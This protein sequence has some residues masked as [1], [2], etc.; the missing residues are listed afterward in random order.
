MSPERALQSPVFLFYLTLA[1]SLLIVAGIVF[2]ILRWGFRKNLSHALRAYGGWLLIVPVLLLAFFL[3]REA[4]ILLVILI[5]ALCFREFARAAGLHAEPF[6][7]GV[8][9]IGIAGLGLACLVYDPVSGTRGWYSLF[10]T[11]PVLIIAVI[12][13]IPIMQDR[14]EGQLQRLALA[15]FG[16]IY[17][18]WLLGHLAFL[19]NSEHAYS[20]L[21]YVVLAVELNDVAAYVCGKLIGRH[22]LRRNISPKKTWEGAVGALAFSLLLPW[23]M[24]FTLPDFTVLDCII[25]G[26]IVGIGGQLG[27][28]VI[29]VI[30]RDVG[31]KDMGATIPGHGGILDRIDSLIYVAPLWF[32]FIRFRDFLRL[33]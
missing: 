2:A 8:V 28:L 7:I 32:Y 17:F 14:V 21:G 19:A 26:L 24:R 6:M 30:K 20:Y 31:L 25:A 18:G 3:G 1:A 16:F 15:V 9:Y 5:S 23:V 22:P 27:D 10:M 12:V 29:S 13:V 4:C 33:P 11:V